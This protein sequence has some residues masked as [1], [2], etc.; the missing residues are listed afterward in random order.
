MV[1]SESQSP[2]E[3]DLDGPTLPD[4]WSAASQ[5]GTLIASKSTE[6]AGV[7]LQEDQQE[8]S[9]QLPDAECSP[10]RHHLPEDYLIL[11][12]LERIQTRTPGKQLTRYSNEDID[13][14]SGSPKSVQEAVLLSLNRYRSNCSIRKDSVNG[15]GSESSQKCRNMVKERK[16]SE[17]EEKKMDINISGPTRLT[18]QKLKKKDVIDCE[19]SA[20]KILPMLASLLD[21]NIPL[22]NGEHVLQ[23]NV[24]DLLANRSV[25]RLAKELDSVLMTNSASKI[26][27]VCD[28]LLNSNMPPENGEQELQP[29]VCDLANHS[30]WQLTK[31]LNSV[32]TFKIIASLRNSRL[33]PE[34]VEQTLHPDLLAKH[35][36]RQLA[37]EL[38]SVH[39]PVTD[40]VFKVL[41]LL[42][43]SS[44]L[45]LLLTLAELYIVHLLL[46]DLE[47]SQLLRL[48]VLELTGLLLS[49]ASL[50]RL[51]HKPVRT[52]S[53]ETM[54]MITITL[55]CWV[56]VTSSAPPHPPNLLI[57]MVEG[58]GRTYYVPL[59]GSPN[60]GYCA[61]IAIGV[62]HPQEVYFISN[63]V[64][65]RSG[66]LI[67]STVPLQ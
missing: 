20:F 54:V 41:A 66:R 27:L 24:C 44:F 52:N 28:S 21:S 33:L 22:E 62:K 37:R 3:L 29:D 8:I 48:L 10:W 38:D 67:N 19:Q 18:S 23:L 51:L 17:I 60:S 57:R 4:R 34:N 53:S 25:R 47:F 13:T 61:N 26:S 59:L 12:D 6:Y 50:L 30:I 36:I 32:P 64:C 40:S 31:E 45:L 7:F 11:P 5:F 16:V 39:V 58:E 65:V 56:K 9:E 49:L 43:N 63:T 15:F 35:S 46:F 2:K 55:S 42:L 1:C 14:Q